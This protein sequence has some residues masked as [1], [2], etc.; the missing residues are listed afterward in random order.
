MDVFTLL[1]NTK[2]R[3]ELTAEHGLSLYLEACGKRIL[4]DCGQSG[5]FAEN[6]RKMGVDLSTV[7]FM[8]LSHGH[9]DHGGGLRTFLRC[10]DHAP[11]YVNSHVFEPHYHG[12]EKYIGLDPALQKSDRFRYVEDEVN[13]GD[14]ICL[15][16]GKALPQPFGFDPYGLSV[17]EHGVLRPD[18]FVHEQ[19]LELTEN[20]QKILLSG[21]SHRGILNIVDF[22]KPDILIGGFHF[23]KLD[24]DGDGADVLERSAEI[25]MDYPTRYFTCHCTGV[26]Q[27]EFLKARMGEKLSYLAAGSH[28]SL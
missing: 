22:F 11:V 1:E 5:A 17:E 24:P 18:D 28:I 21:C 16:P 12:P 25:L 8:V 2:L 7:D 13:L 27:Y 14:G 19:Y 20:G 23:K 4:F 26:A 3:E 6:A 15:I 9:Y 10:N